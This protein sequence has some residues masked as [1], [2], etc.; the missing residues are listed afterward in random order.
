M[1]PKL[2]LC[3]SVLSLLVSVIIE[4]NCMQHTNMEEPL[5]KNFGNFIDFFFFL[6][7]ISSRSLETLRNQAS[8]EKERDKK[9]TFLPYLFPHS[10][11]LSHNVFVFPY[12]SGYNLTI[13]WDITYD[14]VLKCTY[15]QT[16]WYSRHDKN[17]R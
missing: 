6:N 13:A 14:V 15:N 8:Q 12:S 7:L 16:D 3:E 5:L 9:K 17:S 10:T 11:S 4:I 2:C 1:F